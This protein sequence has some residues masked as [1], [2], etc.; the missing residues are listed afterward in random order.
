LGPDPVFDLSPMGLGT[1]EGLAGIR[2]FWESWLGTFEQYE[3]EPEQIL[4]LGNGVTLAAVTQ[5][6]HPG[7]SRGEVRLRYAAVAVWANGMAVRITN[8]TDIDEARS[9]AE[10]L[11]G[12]RG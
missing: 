1:Y 10:R 9:A 8:Y 12:E 7:G 2:A 11:A 4:D 3:I 6:G 5:K